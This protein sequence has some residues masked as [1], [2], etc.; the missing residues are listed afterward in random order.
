IVLIF[1]GLKMLVEYFHVE[2]PVYISLLVIVTC[3]IASIIYSINAS[4]RADEE[5]RADAGVD[6][7]IH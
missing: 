7:E 6:R 2:I 5:K 1:I 4:N 3:I